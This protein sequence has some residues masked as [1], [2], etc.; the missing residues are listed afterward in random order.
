M[1][2]QTTLDDF[3]ERYP[4]TYAGRI[5]HVEVQV[6]GIVPPRGLSGTLTNAGISQYRTPTAA[7]AP[8]VPE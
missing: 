5:T 4:G 1:E 6:D 7:P 3:D 2:F 8:E